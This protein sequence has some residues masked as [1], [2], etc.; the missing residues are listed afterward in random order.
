MKKITHENYPDFI[1]FTS[2]NVNVDKM[3]TILYDKMF[4]V[5]KNSPYQIIITQGYRSIEEQNRLYSQGRTTS[6]KIVT[7]A[8]GG[9]SAHNYGLAFDF[10]PLING[11]IDWDDIDKFKTVAAIGIKAGLRW[12]GDWIKSKDY[13]HLEYTNGLTQEQ[14]KLCYPSKVK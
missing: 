14:F 7:N 2:N 5:A 1:L 4:Y 6:G 9:Q 3:D 12:G 10:A 13:P 8:K 11:K